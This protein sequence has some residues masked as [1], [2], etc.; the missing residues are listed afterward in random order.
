MLP[1]PDDFVFCATFDMMPPDAPRTHPRRP[2]VTETEPSWS[3]PPLGPAAATIE[4]DCTSFL[5][6]L[7]EGVDVGDRPVEAGGVMGIG[8]SGGGE[9]DDA[10]D[11]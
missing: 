6:T 9:A 1:V 10:G 2:T 11:D 4:L 3:S 5:G 7:G 8:Q